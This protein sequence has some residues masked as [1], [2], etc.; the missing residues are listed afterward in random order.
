LDL[1]RLSLIGLKPEERIEFFEAIMEGYCKHCGYETPEGKE[2]YC[3]RD[4]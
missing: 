1:F 4:E 2:C 3:E